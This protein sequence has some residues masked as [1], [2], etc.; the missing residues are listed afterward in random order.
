MNVTHEEIVSLIEGVGVSVDVSSISGDAQLR[1][2]GIDSLEMMNVFLAVE[3][4]FNVH[5]SDE[6]GDSL[7]A[8]NDIINYLQRQTS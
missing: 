6:E 2:A 7:I 3:E 1:K 5:I 4:R 8:I